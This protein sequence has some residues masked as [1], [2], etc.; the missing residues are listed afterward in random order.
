MP[1]RGFD[2]LSESRQ[3]A[4]L[5]RL[6]L[7]GIPPEKVIGVHIN[8]A[9]YGGR[10]RICN[11]LDESDVVCHIRTLHSIEEKALFGG[12][13]DSAYDKGEGRDANIAY[14]MPFEQNADKMVAR[15]SREALA[16]VLGPKWQAQVNLAHKAWLQGDSRKVKALGY[17]PLI[18][19][20]HF[21]QRGSFMAADTLELQDG[22]V[23]VLGNTDGTPINADYGSVILHLNA[24]IQVIGECTINISGELDHIPVIEWMAS[25]TASGSSS[26]A[27]SGPGA[28]VRDRA[29]VRRR[30]SSRRRERA[31]R[32][33][34]IQA[35]EALGFS[36]REIAMA[37]STELKATNGPVH[38]HEGR[39]SAALSHIRTA[40]T[41]AEL[42]ALTN[43]LDR[44]Y[45]DVRAGELS[46][47]GQ[48]VAGRLSRAALRRALSRRDARAVRTQ[49][50]TATLGTREQLD[51]LG[52]A[53]ERATLPARVTVAAASKMVIEAGQVVVIGN[54]EEPSK[55]FSMV[56]EEL[57]IEHGGQLILASPTAL[58][59]G[60]VARGESSGG[61]YATDIFVDDDGD[62]PNLSFVGG[63]GAN[64]DVGDEGG[65][66]NN[67]A[68]GTNGS[69][70]S[71]GCDAQPTNGGEGGPGGV[72]GTGGD[73]LNGSD[74]PAGTI[75]VWEIHDDVPLYFYNSGGNGGI[76]GP[77]GT[78]GQGGSGG[79]AGQTTSKCTT[80]ASSGNGGH[81]GN[82][83]TGG[84]GGD[85]GNGSTVIVN[86]VMWDNLDGVRAVT[87][88]SQGGTGGS[89]GGGGGGGGAGG[90]D[91]S[92]G[93]PGSFGFEG[94]DG[95]DGNVGTFD[96]LQVDE[97][98]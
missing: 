30:G 92:P 27:S 31:Q 70:G 83:G 49:T 32:A 51:D 87:P 90:S 67:G 42:R 74:A 48:E 72:G 73:G 52:E 23:A 68:N 21:P 24:Q 95:E 5:A 15:Y 46:A 88:A 93:G 45:Q 77:G 33:S 29:P 37:I 60:R 69:D 96:F 76:G 6:D 89:P 63:D 81:G 43:P 82:G 57:I 18:N 79:A 13:P 91:A 58:T 7:L 75:N 40:T 84:A 8:S 39:D 17:E 19:K 55:L 64:G 22:D 4:F 54:R 53:V 28:P 16:R 14:P 94:V 44:V 9:D 25:D 56:I 61:F 97:L 12:V 86:Y 71:C 62:T 50:L 80:A 59:V 85:A 78:G 3:K 20:M 38:I 26:E 98:P 10:I 47:A 41:A 65:H 1:K 2:T 34:F 35:L 66:G 11:D 36:E